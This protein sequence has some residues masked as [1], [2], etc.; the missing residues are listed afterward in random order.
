MVFHLP[1]CPAQ[2][3]DSGC[4]REAGQPLVSMHNHV[5]LLSRPQVRAGLG[6]QLQVGPGLFKEALLT[7][8]S[9]RL[10]EHVLT[11]SPPG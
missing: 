3:L 8:G 1:S 5:L 2:L 10:L 7:L 9:V 4:R 11:A 6:L